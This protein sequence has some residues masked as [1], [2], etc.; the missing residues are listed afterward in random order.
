MFLANNRDWK[1]HKRLCGAN[2]E[3]MN[4]VYQGTEESD[5]KDMDEMIRQHGSVA[6]KMFHLR[7]PKAGPISAAARQNTALAG[8]SAPLSSESAS[9]TTVPDISSLSLQDLD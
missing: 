8:L 7:K 9:S 5:T 1:D 3:R 4:I 6:D 2:P